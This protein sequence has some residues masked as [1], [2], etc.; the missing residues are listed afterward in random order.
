MNLFEHVAPW[1]LLSIIVFLPIAGAIC[2]MF[3]PN[4]RPTVARTLGVLFAT[5]TFGITIYL[6]VVFDTDIGGFQWVETHSWIPSLGVNYQLGI[7]GFSLFMVMLTGFLFPLMIIGSSHITKRV[8]HFIVF[9]LI[10]EGV[11]M[12]VFAAT[13]MFLF[14][15]FWELTL[16]PTYFLIGYWGGAQR[17]KAAVKFFIYTAVGS[18]FLLAAI[19]SAGLLV[20]GPVS[21]DYRAIFDT[22]YGMWAQRL[23]FWGF[24]IGFIFK[25]PVVPFHTWLPDAH[26]QAPTAGS[27][28]LAGVLLKIG[29]YGLIQF[30]VP[31]FPRA[32][33]EAVPI[34]LTLGVIGIIYTALVAIAQKDAKR[35]IA[36]S[37]IGHMGFVVMGIFAI[38]TTALQGA[39]FQ[40]L[41]HGIATAGLFFLI[42]FFYDRRHTHLIKEMGGLKNQMP[43]YA[44]AF[45][46]VAFASMGVPGLNSFVG[47]ML[48]LFGTF[49]VHRW[50]AI[51]AAVG[52]ILVAVYMM[53]TYKKLFTGEIT[54][55]ANKVL[56]D[57][58][59]REI[60]VIAPIILVIIGLGI[61]PKPVLDRIEA[62]ATRMIIR[63]EAATA[64]TPQQY[65]EPI[66][67]ASRRNVEFVAEILAL[68]EV[69]EEDQED[70][71]RR[72][73]ERDKLERIADAVA[74]GS[75]Q[76]EAASR[77]GGH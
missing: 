72:Y 31:L 6:G 7:D 34:L 51:A 77:G 71:M 49:V 28:D 42:G 10:L 38:T 44:A 8:K 12:G 40:M 17:K 68:I 67:T 76:R 32:A 33:V 23:L 50:W 37:S 21:F 64:N 15:L 46:I 63:V 24:T 16:V 20:D 56:A 25:V 43:I 4:T 18:A 26:T 45:L 2:V 41:N 13:D 30:A 47:E 52:I 66:E 11:Q 14:F 62:S 36:Y 27:A 39:V 60:F 22:E 19:V 73:E 69:P 57:L 61:Y 9:L 74:E 58:R 29:A 5:V 1:P 55:P 3:V 54:N 65:I 48:T 35:L 53:L 59:P 70:L 75:E